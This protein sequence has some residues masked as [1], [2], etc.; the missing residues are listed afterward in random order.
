MFKKTILIILAIFTLTCIFTA[1]NN[2]SDNDGGN[3]CVHDYV[4]TVTKEP[5]CGENGLARWIC[6]KCGKDKGYGEETIY[7]TGEHKYIESV[8]DEPTCTFSGDKKLTCSVCG[9][10]EIEYSVIPE[11][12]HDW[13]EADCTTPQVCKRCNVESGVSLGHDYSA[14]DGIC[15]RCGYGVKFILPTTPVTISCYDYKGRLEQSCLIESI[16]I[17]KE[18]GSRYYN[19]IFLVERTYHNK[20]NSYSADCKFGWKL[21]DEDGLVVCSGTGYTD[22]TISVGEKS[23]E[24]ISFRIGSDS[25]DIKEGNTYTLVLLDIG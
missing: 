4:K 20:G 1:C 13:D 14:I 5:T 23:K 21:Y 9:Y 18:Y 2:K 11:L 25:D 7:A 3:E 17:E 8:H 6:S 10:V 12:G 22:A 24:T 15:T 16:T 19:L